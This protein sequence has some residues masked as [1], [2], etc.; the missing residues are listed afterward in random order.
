MLNED[1]RRVWR[2]MRPMGSSEIMAA[3]LSARPVGCGQV[4]I[5]RGRTTPVV[6]ALG[7]VGAMLQGPRA[8][9][10]RYRDG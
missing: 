7:W 10:T 4:V 5:F 2:G 1:A 6:G 3:L 9:L 8:E